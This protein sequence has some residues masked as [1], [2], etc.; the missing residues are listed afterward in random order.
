MTLKAVGGWSASHSRAGASTSPSGR[1]VA[2]AARLRDAP[3]PVRSRRGSRLSCPPVERLA[4]EDLSAADIH[5]ALG[6]RAAESP[7]R[8]SYEPTRQLVYEVRLEP[9]VQAG[10][11]YRRRLRVRPGASST[12]RPTRGR[13]TRTPAA[14][15]P[16]GRAHSVAQDNL[17]C[18]RLAQSMSSFCSAH[19]VSVPPSRFGVSVLRRLP[20]ACD[21][22]VTPSLSMPT[23]NQLIRKGRSKK[24]GRIRPLRCGSPQKRGIFF[25][26]R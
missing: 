3:R 6:E 22:K 2:K 9:I 12:R 17:T 24:P 26:R 16:A 11:A 1:R 13:W 8:T 25:S 5:R 7:F 21:Q 23:V 4:R 10:A 15:G 20:A 18:A 19:G 14:E